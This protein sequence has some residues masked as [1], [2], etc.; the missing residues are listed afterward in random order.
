MKH[1][2]KKSLIALIA[3][4]FLGSLA[5]W[6]LTRSQENSLAYRTAE[7][8]RGDLVVTINATGT[9]E[10]E[11]VIDVGA[12][13]AGRIVSFGKDAKEKT[14]DYGSLVEAGTV[15]ARIDDSL[16]AADVAQA[17]AQLLSNKAGLQKAKADLFRTEQEWKRA[18]LL[19]P[20]EALSQSSYEGYESAH[21]NAL[22]QVAV[23]EASIRQAEAALKRAQRN[24]GYCT[25]TSPVKGIIIDRRVN[26]GQTVVA[27]LNAPSLF[28][29]AKDLTRIQVWVAV[30][31]ADIGKIRPGQP[32]TFTVDAFPNETFRG[33]VGKIRLNAAMTQ[34]VVTYTV[35]I[36]T[37]NADGRLLPYLTAN[38][39]FQ[40]QKLENVLQAPNAALRW[41]PPVK[42]GKGPASAK[43]P[44]GGSLWVLDEKR[45]PRRIEVQAGPSDGI[46]TAVESAEL[47]EDMQVITG[48]RMSEADRNG[49]GGGNPFTPKFGAGK[50]AKGEK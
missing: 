28:L 37:D 43:T 44:A 26:I 17:E 1:P 20:S 40:L 23:S 38:V 19:G 10:P 4:L 11:E 2:G 22:A 33:E 29:L 48:I 45:T 12:Q 9:V 6:Q 18:Q 49:S 24:L 47:R 39:L 31:E 46:N 15:L 30:N 8:K 32:V 36:T 3:V 50:K 41:S 25:I 5:A 14:V 16:Y 27:S 35:E 42:E 7:L 21:K 34:N 13:V